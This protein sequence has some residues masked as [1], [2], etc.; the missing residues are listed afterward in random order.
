VPQ[1]DST[2]RID[3]C[4]KAVRQV[5][6]HTMEADLAGS[7][8]TSTRNEL[9]SLLDVIPSGIVLVSGCLGRRLYC[10]M[11]DDQGIELYY[12]AVVLEQINAE[13]AGNMRWDCSVGRLVKR[14]LERHV[15]LV[16][17]V[18]VSLLSLL[19]IVICSRADTRIARGTGCSLVLTTRPD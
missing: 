10:L 7:Y 15:G 9:N 3:M 14:L 18:D 6:K 11:A 4:L 2:R 12:F 17:V 5:V 13:L 8:L 16:N 19:L 1:I